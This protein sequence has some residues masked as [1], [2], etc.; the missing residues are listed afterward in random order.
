MVN[1]KTYTVDEAL[2]RLQNYCSYQERCHQEVKQKLKDMHMIPEVID[3][4][5]VLLIQDNFLNE[6]RFAKT[7]VRGKFKIKKWGRHRLT[8][9]LNKKNVS[10]NNINQALKE[11]DELEYIDTFNSLAEKRFNSISETNKLKKKKKLVDY[12]LYRGWE[13][14]LVYNKANALIK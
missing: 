7:Y 13:S 5:I 2:N 8:L 11:I 3:Y 14:H 10:K 9:E 1:R 12:L 4:I 6:E